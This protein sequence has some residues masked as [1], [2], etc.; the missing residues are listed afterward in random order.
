MPTTVEVGT[1]AEG[2]A[3][4]LLEQRGYRILERNFRCRSGELDIVAFHGDVLCFVE[5]R[6]RGND[7]HGSALD[8]INRRKQKQVAR[9]ALMYIALRSPQFQRSRFDVV[10]ITEGRAV[11]LED[12]WRL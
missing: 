4:A 9:V 3:I 10:A 5:V 2:R 7:V 1:D 11:L 12:A 6:S 8:A